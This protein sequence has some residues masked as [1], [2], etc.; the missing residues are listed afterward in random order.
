MRL[1]SNLDR[2]RS[3]AHGA[4]ITFKLILQLDVALL[5]DKGHDVAAVESVDRTPQYLQAMHAVAA[6]DQVGF[7]EAMGDKGI[8]SLLNAM[9]GQSGLDEV[10]QLVAK[11]DL[12]PMLK[13][14]AETTMQRFTRTTPLG[15]HGRRRELCSGYACGP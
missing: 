6:G 9:G 14:I 13:T 7:A 15:W 5:A 3:D 10:R 1:Q 11:D 12:S 8:A 4:D 2:A